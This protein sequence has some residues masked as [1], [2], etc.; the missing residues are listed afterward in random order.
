MRKL[1]NDRPARFIPERWAVTET[2]YDETANKCEESIFAVANGYIGVRGFFEEGVCGGAQ[3]SDPVTMLNG[4]YEYH[5][6]NYTW[7]RPGFPARTQAITRQANPLDIRVEVDGEP[8]QMPREGYR[9]TLDFK[10]GV[11]TRTFSHTTAK[12]NK[13][14]LTFERFACQQEKHLLVSRIRIC[15]ERAAQIRIIGRLRTADSGAKSLSGEDEVYEPLFLRREGEISAAAYRTRKSKFSVACAIREFV[16]GNIAQCGY[17]DDPDALVTI[18]SFPL[19]AGE[20]ANYERFAAFVC[21][22]DRE[23]F[24]EFAAHKASEGAAMGFDAL[25]SG[26]RCVLDKFWDVSD[27]AIDDDPLV[28][29]GIRFSLFQVFQ[30]AGRDGY[31]NISANGLSGTIYSGQ[32]F[33]DT[34]MYMMPMFTYGMQD[35]S[36]AL[37]MY[38]YHIL[39]K[40]RE[41]AKQ[42]DEQGALYSWNT[43]NGEECGTVFEAVTAQYHINADIAFAMEKYFDA[44]ADETFMAEYGAEMLFEMSKCLSH[45]GGFVEAR[46]GKFC[47]NVVCGPDEYNPIVDN[48]LYTNFLVKRMFEF[49]LRIRALLAEKYPQKLAQLEQKCAMNEEEFKRI[50]LAAE[51]MYFPYNEEYGIYMQDDN[52]MYKDAVEIDSIPAEKLPLLF[53]L[54]PLNLWRYQIC[55]QADIVLLTFLCSDFF[56]RD[57]IRKIFDYYEPKT[58]H[59]SSLSAAVHS[60]VACAVGYKSEAY[61]YLKHAAR[62]DLDDVNGNTFAGLHAAC[63]G[64]AWM[65]IVNG[66]AGLRVYDGALHF[67]PMLHETWKRYTFKLHYQNRLLQIRVEKDKT[68]YRLLEGKHLTIYHCGYAIEVTEEEI[69]AVNKTD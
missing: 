15:A 56:D 30:S 48:N 8:V 59:D 6:H 14:T 21:D 57:Q 37:L 9:R 2:K 43:I 52:F 28:Q 68:H 26:S 29:Q 31:T 23:D 39:D 7:R 65:L 51:R 20:E 58:I 61:N 66:Y 46:G 50:S 11:L 4:V 1:Y 27:I 19:A 3:F 44:S 55:K 18:H 42:M 12:G 63:M 45:R 35:I 53:S 13:V 32:T 33:W 49:T 69:S 38:R 34:E 10:T 62:L 17:D 41:R 16:A 60:I 67:A 25:L 22:K 5:D 54:H 40:S 64:G 36:R 24:S 47:I